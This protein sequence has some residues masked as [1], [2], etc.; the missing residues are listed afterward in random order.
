MRRY[1]F[2]EKFFQEGFHGFSVKPW[3]SID[4]H[5]AMGN[6]HQNLSDWAEN[7]FA[8]SYDYISE[9]VLRFFKNLT[10]FF[11]YQTNT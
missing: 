8:D 4:P 2:E 7:F 1:V 10:F 9:V 3:F 5:L 11:F 6:P